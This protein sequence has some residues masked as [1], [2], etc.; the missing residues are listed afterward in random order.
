MLPDDMVQRRQWVAWRYLP[1][2]KP[3]G[4]PRKVPFT[5]GTQ[6]EA[7]TNDPTTWGPYADA[8]ADVSA[9]RADGIWFV[10]SK[11][12]PYFGIDL[13]DCRNPKTSEI[14][15]WAQTIIDRFGTYTEPSP[16]GTGIHAEICPPKPTAPR[17]TSK[18]S[19]VGM[20]NDE[21][22]AK[23]F[24]AANGEKIRRLYEGDTTE[25]PSSQTDPGFSNEADLALVSLLCGYTPDDE[26]LADLLRTSGLYRRK[27]DRHD[28]VA[29]TIQRARSTQTWWYSRDYRSGPRSTT[30]PTTVGE[31]PD[32]HDTTPDDLRAMVRDL[33]ARLAEKDAH[34]VRLQERLQKAEEKAQRLS[35]ERSRCMEVLRAPDLHPGQ[36]LTHFAS[37]TGKSRP[38]PGFAHLP[39]ASPR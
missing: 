8:C 28:Y 26:Q 2:E 6:H 33:T 7:K 32:L 13:D 36:K 12:D 3:G 29:R 15:P 38:R 11:N 18:W 24:N 17:P 9:G 27:L 31:T 20:T 1:P 14:D 10:F 35:F 22:L 30:P 5:P 34:I 39:H 4:E 19:G 23:A 21:I 25:Y 37:R 16:S